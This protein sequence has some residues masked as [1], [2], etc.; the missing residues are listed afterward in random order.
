MKTQKVP[1]NCNSEKAVYFSNAKSVITCIY[2]GKGQTKFCMRLNNYKSAHKSF[3]IKME[4]HR[5]NFM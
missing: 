5:S 3:Q 1:L 4:E 2:V